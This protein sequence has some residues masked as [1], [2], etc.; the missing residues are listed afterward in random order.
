LTGFVIWLTGLSAAGK[1]T[2]GSIVG[3]RL[4]EGGVL[5]DY[6]DGDVVRTHL[7]KGLGFSK[8]DRDTNIER[9]GWVAS[10]LARAGAVVIVSA[11]SPY[12]EARQKARA[13]VEEHSTFVLVH[14]A[15]S[16]EEC[17]R[18]DPKGLYA[19]AHAGEITGFTGVDDPYEIPEHAELRL[20]TEGQTPDTSAAVVLA[21][22]EE[23]GLLPDEVA[24]L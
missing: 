24:A 12:E 11:I 6:L 21:K 13:L 5:V 20:G 17:E 16:I 19:R 15:T 4:E 23:L 18:R 9:I 14:V 22:L 3:D 7:S 2:I 10:R 1:S 8:E